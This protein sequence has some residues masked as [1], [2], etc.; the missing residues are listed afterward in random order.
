MIWRIYVV[1]WYLWSIS[2]SGLFI[3]LPDVSQLVLGMDTKNE[4]NDEGS[5]ESPTSVLEDEVCFP[6]PLMAFLSFY[7]S[8]CLIHISM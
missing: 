3:L 7:F 4:M 1:L 6:F 8:F 2:F 5:A